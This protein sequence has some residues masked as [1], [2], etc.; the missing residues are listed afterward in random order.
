ME[1]DDEIIKE[2]LDEIE[3]SLKDP[4]GIISHQRRL[5]FL[6]SLGAVHLI[7]V[8]LKRLNV[9]KSGAKINHLWLKK[10]KE[11]AKKLVANQITCPIENLNKIDKLL[12]TTYDLEKERNELAYG[13]KV[14][15]EK[16]KEKIAVFLNFKKEVEND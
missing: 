3:S 6:L 9:F 16:L 15:E 1:K 10:K 4:Q 2:V 12:D 14:S 5:A 13:K 8:Y 7:E 11:N